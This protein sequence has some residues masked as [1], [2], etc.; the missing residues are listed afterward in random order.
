MPSEAKMSNLS[1]LNWKRWFHMLYFRTKFVQASSRKSFCY[2]NFAAK[3]LWSTLIKKKEERKMII[4]AI[5][6]YSQWERK[7][8]DPPIQTLKENYKIKR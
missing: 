8:F 4:F 7:R 5:L 1:K 6:I 3:L 2:V